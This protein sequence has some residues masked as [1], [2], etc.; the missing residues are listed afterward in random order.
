MYITQRAFQ[1]AV[2]FKHATVMDVL[3]LNSNYYKLLYTKNEL[4]LQ[5]RCVILLYLLVSCKTD[6]F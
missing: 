4:Q 2:N 6:Q 3:Y 5:R 1:T